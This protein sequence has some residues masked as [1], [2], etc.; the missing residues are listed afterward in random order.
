MDEVFKALADATRRRLLDRLSGQDGQSLRELCDGLGM[1]RQAVSKHLAVLEQARL[2]A[3]VRRGREKLHYL[4]PVP[5][6]DIAERWIGRYRR[7]HVR[8]LADLRHTLESD[9]MSKP[10]FVYVTVIRTTPE[11]LWQA[12]TDPAFIRRYHENTGPDSDWQVGSP[13]RWKMSQ[14]GEFRD[15]GQVV[16]ESEPYRKLSY[17]WHNYEPEIAAMFGWSDEK[18]AELRKERVSKVSFE[19]EPIG[20]AVKLTVVHDDFEP[21][22]E[23]LAG[24]SEGWP[25]I[26]SSLKTLLETGETLP[27]EEA[28]ADQG[29]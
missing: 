6:N 5:I 13:V 15:Y 14:G 23:M 11:R 28:A 24:I 29:A 10:E 2:V 9:T 20:D 25:L 4:N 27:L 16:L 22:S 19:I 3:A 21:G 18:L 1:S 8:A 12:L 26:L 7:G 17:T